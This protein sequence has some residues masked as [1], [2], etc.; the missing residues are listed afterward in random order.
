MSKQPEV[1]FQPKSEWQKYSCL[2]CAT[3]ASIEAV[4]KTAHI[5]CCESK[6]CKEQAAK[7]ALALGR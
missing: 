1:E 7:L 2:F 4:Y 3:H 5:R 6:E